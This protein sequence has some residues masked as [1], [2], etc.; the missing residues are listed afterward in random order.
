[1]S[2]VERFTYTDPDGNIR[3][4]TGAVIAWGDSLDMASDANGDDQPDLATSCL[5]KILPRSG[6]ATLPTVTPLIEGVMS[7]PASVLVV[8][9]TGVGK[10]FVTLS[11]AGS[12]ATGRK[13]LGRQVTRRRALFVVGEGAYG[14]DKRVCAWEDAWNDAAAVTDDWL[15]FM[16]KPDSLSNQMTWHQLTE[17]ATAG[18]YG[19]VVLDTF[20]SLAPDADE[21]KDA[22]QT[23][24]RLSDLSAATDGCAVLVHHPGWSDTGRARGGYQL[25]A[26]ADEVLILRNVA[27]GSDLFTMTRKKVKDGPAGEV[28]WL[29]RSPSLGSVVIEGSRPNDA[30]VPLRARIMFVLTNYGDIGATGPQLI[31]EIEPESKSAFYA[32]LSKLVTECAVR[33]EGTSSRK[34]YYALSSEFPPCGT[35]SNGSPL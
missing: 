30:S 1:V 4:E 9:A 22:A 7:S 2:S 33:A 24:R 16:V 12:V 25:E 21:T 29:R 34:R 35:E 6:L 27:E 11:F 19:L 3:N 26:N 18:R 32:A 10:S 5:G 28:H 23:M 14:L 8:G 20:S 15:T 31:E 13:W 17:Y